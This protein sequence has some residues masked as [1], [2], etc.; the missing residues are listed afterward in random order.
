MNGR[1]NLVRTARGI[2]YA[3]AIPAIAFAF[4]G[5]AKTDGTQTSTDSTASASSTATAVV[6]TGG[7]GGITLP[8]GFCATVFADDVGHA[9]HVVVNANG[10]VYVN[11]WS[12]PYYQG[13]THAGGFIVALRDTN[14]DG[15]ADIIKRFGPDA[16]HRNGGGTGIGIYKGALYAEE[17]D[18]LSKRIVR[19]TLSPDSLAPTSTTS[20]TIV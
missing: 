1:I 20:E 8:P 7:N 16:Q 13:P 4:S 11:T 3:L 9:R 5:C 17:G 14:A 2:P 18:T 15:T 12:G 19:Y 10:D 6:C